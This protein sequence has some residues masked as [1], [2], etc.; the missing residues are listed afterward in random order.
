MAVQEKQLIG[1]PELVIDKV[2]ITHQGLNVECREV[3]RYSDDSEAVEEIVRK[4]KREP[5]SDL[6]QA[7]KDLGVHLADICKC[8]R[9]SV[10]VTGIRIEDL[11]GEKPRALITGKVNTFDNQKSAINTHFLHLE[12]TAYP[13]RKELNKLL[14]ECEKE[15]LLYMLANKVAQPTL[16][17]QGP[18][19]VAV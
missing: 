8:D 12:T 5:H 10:E 13:H 3:Y 7:F 4:Y 17:Q 15:L 6:T 18:M 16:W 2:K 11:N 9:P 19:K 1:K 14:L